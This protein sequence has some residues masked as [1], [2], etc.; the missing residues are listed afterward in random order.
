MEENLWEFV[1]DLNLKDKDKE[2]IQMI[3]IKNLKITQ[4][5]KIKN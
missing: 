3:Q 4:N 1:C 2:K 5:Q